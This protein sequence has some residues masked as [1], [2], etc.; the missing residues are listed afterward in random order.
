AHVYIDNPWKHVCSNSK[1][2]PGGPYCNSV[3]NTKGNPSVNPS[4]PQDPHGPRGY[5]DLPRPVIGCSRIH[6]QIHSTTVLLDC[7]AASNNIYAQPAVLP[8]Y[9][10]F[11]AVPANG[12]PKLVI[13]GDDPA[14]TGTAKKCNIDP[15]NAANYYF[16]YFDCALSTPCPASLCG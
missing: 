14:L 12:G 1:N 11:P 13:M 15:G 9:P 16:G 7:P 8:N 4:D 10:A 5:D 3:G 6:P 2:D